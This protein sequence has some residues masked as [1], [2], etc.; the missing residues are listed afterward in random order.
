MWSQ[1]L[2]GGCIFN[3]N[4]LEEC[5]GTYPTQKQDELKSALNPTTRRTSV[6]LKAE[7]SCTREGQS[8]PL[9]AARSSNGESGPAKGIIG[10]F[11]VKRIGTHSPEP[12]KGPGRITLLL[13]PQI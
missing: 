13:K 7:K 4:P 11:F 6:G 12:I 5:T 3:P 10:E 2:S 1:A 8:L 9:K